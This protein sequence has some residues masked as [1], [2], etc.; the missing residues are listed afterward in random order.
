MNLLC[1]ATTV[2]FH[3]HSRPLVDDNGVQ[4]PFVREE[5]WCRVCVSRTNFYVVCLFFKLFPDS[6]WYLALIISP[7]KLWLIFS[8]LRM[9]QKLAGTPASNFHRFYS[10]LSVAFFLHD[11]FRRHPF[12]LFR[13]LLFA[14]SMSWETDRMI[15]QENK[16]IKNREEAKS[17]KSCQFTHNCEWVRGPTHRRRAIHCECSLFTPLSSPIDG[18]WDCQVSEKAHSI[19]WDL[20][21]FC[22]HWWFLS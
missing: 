1:I 12:L 2:A 6:P 5:K 4:K 21:Y 15:N 13:R 11:D 9:T 16:D 18:D 20:C 7:T 19:E 22:C 10:S 14:S 3:S 17:K 8:L